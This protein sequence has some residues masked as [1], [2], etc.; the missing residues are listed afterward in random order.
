MNELIPLSAPSIEGNAWKYVKD[1]LDTQ[2][3]SS[4]G[5]Y[6]ELFERSVERF[7]GARH[8]VAGV[9]GT[10]CLHLALSSLGIKRGDGVLTPALTFIATANAVS[11]CGAVPIFLDCDPVRFN[12]DLGALEDYLENRCRRRAG[13][14]LSPEGV[15]LKAVLPAHILGFPVDMP[16]LMKI[17]RGRS[18]LV[19][20]DAAESIGSRIAGRHTGT[21]ADAGVLSFNGNKLVTCG[22]GGMI[23]TDDAALARRLKHLTQQAKAHTQEYIHDAIGYNYRLTNPAAALGLSQMERLDGFLAKRQRIG[24]WYQSRLTGPAV[25]PVPPKVTWN[26]WLL[27]VQARSSREKAALLLRLNAAGCQ[28]RALWVPVPR[29][30]PYLKAARAPIP[31]A[32]RAYATILNI[33][34]STSLTPAQADKVARLLQGARL[35]RLL[36]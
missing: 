15:P 25:E 3:V 2:W 35:D 18:L 27:S 31:N 4:V 20:E 19:L 36:I 21:F 23:L 13:R 22:G 1:C 9:N 30:K 11:Y 6:V 16:R 7:T 26:R 34:S 8:A 17:A 33:P 10:A 5:R 24:R 29:Q 32:E 14:T 12:L 28:A